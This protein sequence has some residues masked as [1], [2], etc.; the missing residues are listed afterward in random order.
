M[1]SENP[2]NRN[3][4]RHVDVEVQ[5]LRDLIRDGH[6]KLVK[7]AGALYVSDVLTKSLA[8]PAFEKHWEH[9]W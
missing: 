3:R 5:I 6:V 7:C 2:A 4:S 9:M 8:R 1:M